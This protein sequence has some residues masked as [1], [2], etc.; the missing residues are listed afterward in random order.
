MIVETD[1]GRRRFDNS[2]EARARRRA[3][4]L[5]RLAAQLL[6]PAAERESGK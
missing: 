5:R 1:D 4:H 3:P 2:I 6:W